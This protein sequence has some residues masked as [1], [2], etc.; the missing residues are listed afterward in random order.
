MSHDHEKNLENKHHHHHDD[1]CEDEHHH[2]DGDCR[3]EH[4]HKGGCA[5]CNSGL[6]ETIEED[7][8]KSNK[9]LIIFGIGVILLVIG[10]LLE[11]FSFNPEIISQIVFLIAVIYVGHHIIMEGVMELLSGKVKIELLVTI[12]TIGAFLL[13]SGEEGALLMVLFYLGEYL[14]EY[15]L[16][17]SKSSIVKLVKLSPDTAY[18]KRDDKTKEE[19]VENLKIG[20][21]VIV[22]PGDKIPVDGDIIKGETSVNQ[23]SI[24]GESLAVSKKVGDEVYAST[25]NEEGYIEV[26]VTKN[27][28]DTI[29]AKIVDL[30]KNSEK[31][32]AKIDIFIDKF[33]KYY[34]PIVVVIAILVA[35]IPAVFFG[36]SITQWTYRALTI[37][38]IA[39]PCAL[40]ISTPVSIVSSI[41]K[42]T[43]NGILIKGGE[44]VE[45]LSRI[46]EILFDKTGTLTEGKLKI[47]EINP[48]GDINKEDIIKIA[49]SIEA[50]S[51]HPIA[52]TFNEYQKENNI[53]LY[54]VTA[55]KSIA[56]K[57]LRGDING[58]TYYIGKESLIKENVVIDNV[59][60]K[61]TVILATDSEV[62]G[63]ITLSDKIRE[64]SK[65][66]ISK[67]KS[68][69]IRTTMI[70]GD[71]KETAEIVSHDLGIDKY[72][73]DLLPQQKVEIVK[74]AVEKYHDVAMVGDG[75]NDA[76]S[77]AMANVGIAMG[78]EGAD[79]AIETAD[80]V[81][82][83]DK[84]SKINLL[85][86]LAKK[87]MSKIKVNVTFCLSV[88]VILMILA[89][90]GFI[91][92]WE[93]VVLGDMG[94]TL[95]V[96]ANSLMLAK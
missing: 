41:T 28:N 60:K 6:L 80:I 93:A 49:C 17:K 16:N 5:C 56:G 36:Q 54:D 39:C 85:I 90:A 79:A 88:K 51:N 45:E 94:I 81:L 37:L 86:R 76:P 38:V 26:K 77:L 65:S 27:S 53:K 42:G 35:I 23:S 9:P 48:Y 64:E 46:K 69:N 4:N 52:N 82:L 47:D 7:N 50:K 68:Q 61:T 63:L 71:N 43:K 84:I 11:Y 67:L 59:D 92:L 12:A 14:E 62:L 74:E 40:V 33:A 57:G 96:V 34:T 73:A 25:I 66:V 95:I 58:T 91:N 31:N 2:H 32:K 55:F 19:Y 75:V 20:D 15:S 44:Y 83:E 8:E 1:E 18:V 78:L 10:Y 24:T 89:I 3:D 13:G 29:F 21:I 30:I 87:T 22:K 70:T 72:Y